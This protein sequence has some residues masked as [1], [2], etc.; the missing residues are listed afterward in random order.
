MGFGAAVSIGV[1]VWLR[2]V[3]ALAAIA[4]GTGWRAGSAIAG[5]ASKEA[6]GAL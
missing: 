3:P 5:C 1:G 6:P 4:R 2:L